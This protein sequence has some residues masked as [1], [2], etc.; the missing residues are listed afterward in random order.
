MCYPELFPYGETCIHQDI[1]SLEKGNQPKLEEKLKRMLNFCEI[2]ENGKPR[3][4]FV[5]NHDFIYWAYN[6]LMRTKN[7]EETN[8]IF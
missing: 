1:P 8:L 5:E 6:R 3:Y 4:R 7:K 2:D